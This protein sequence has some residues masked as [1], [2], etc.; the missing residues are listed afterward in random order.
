M[1]IFSYSKTPSSNLKQTVAGIESFFL[2]MTLQT[3]AQQKAQA[4]IDRV[5]GTDRL[6]TSADRAHLPYFEALL[7]EVLR[8][9]IFGPIGVLPFFFWMNYP[10]NCRSIAGLPHVASDDDV[11]DGYFIPKGSIIITNNWSVICPRFISE[12]S[13]DNLVYLFL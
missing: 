12:A 5:V 10:C 6:P 13:L 7:T 3:S 9:Y 1:A 11:H 4:E 8:T 2:A